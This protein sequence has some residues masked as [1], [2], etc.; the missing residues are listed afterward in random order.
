[1]QNDWDSNVLTCVLAIDIGTT[2]T[3]LITYQ[4]PDLHV[5][6]CTK[7]RTPLLC[8]TIMENDQ[9]HLDVREIDLNT[10]WVNVA[11]CITEHLNFANISNAAMHAIGICAARNCVA[12]IDKD[13]CEPLSKLI[14]WNDTRC[15]HQVNKVESSFIWNV[16]HWGASLLSWASRQFQSFA[17]LRSKTEH[18]GPKLRWLLN[19]MHKSD[20]M[21]FV[22]L[23]SWIRLKL[24]DARSESDERFLIDET[25]A[26]TT[27]LYNVFRSQWSN[28]LCWQFGIPMHILP[29]VHK[30]GAFGNKDSGR[31]QSK[32]YPP[33]EV[34]IGDSQAALISQQCTKEGD[35][36][37]ILGT[38]AISNFVLSK[39]CSIGTERLPQIGRRLKP[40]NE[41]KLKADRCDKIYFA[42]KLYPYCSCI[43]E[44]AIK[45]KFIKSYHEIDHMLL[46]QQ[47]IDARNKQEIIF[48]HGA[49]G[50]KFECI[51]QDSTHLD[52][53]SFLC[54]MIES[55]AFSVMRLIEN[56]IIEQ[57]IKRVRMTGGCSKIKFLR[58]TLTNLILSKRK[59]ITI[60][61]DDRESSALGVAALVAWN[62][63]N[64]EK[65]RKQILNALAIE[66]T[67]FRSLSLDNRYST[68]YNEVIN[69]RYQKW[70][71]EQVLIEN[72]KY[73][74]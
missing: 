27:G 61:F 49:N 45:L 57:K 68:V 11:Q 31:T 58:E 41:K 19:G 42:Q 44:L 24:L 32:R 21:M 62:S 15:K 2:W 43:I 74:L 51:R 26:S 9:I 59:E 5:L 53:C 3:K 35:M 40:T 67:E 22:G 34:C 55:I 29:K 60:E 73:K 18:V 36:L 39:Q 71:T 66:K 69:K 46:E 38:A 70:K 13:T 7:I 10:L 28:I 64:L 23:D 37:L 56:D 65:Y 6:K 20:K 25:V 1:M 12:L 14:A 52:N 48:T 16:M 63:C 72:R 33:V 30:I 54:S 47:D 17:K 50:F 8:S 4:I